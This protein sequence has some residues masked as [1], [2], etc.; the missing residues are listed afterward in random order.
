M[1]AEFTV[2]IGSEDLRIKVGDDLSIQTANPTL[3]DLMETALILR[4]SPGYEPNPPL[5]AAEYLMDLY[6][7]RDLTFDERE[8]VEG[9]VY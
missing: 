2:T 3:T 7:G 1:S 4:E 5:G 8:Y 6:K 9:R